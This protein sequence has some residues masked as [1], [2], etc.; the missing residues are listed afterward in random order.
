MLK[1]KFRLTR[2]AFRGAR[3]RSGP[4][5]EFFLI[6]ESPSSLPHAR[7]AVLV[8]KKIEKK[9]VKRNQIR[10]RFYRALGALGAPVLLSRRDLIIQVLPPARE[11]PYKEIEAAIERA[12]ELRSRLRK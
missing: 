6:K 10:R 2:E 3:L 7:F 4:R 5:T 9:A 8:P 11:A 1:K 12:L